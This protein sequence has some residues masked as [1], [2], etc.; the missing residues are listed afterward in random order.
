M[1]L[2]KATSRSW[3]RAA[4][5]TWTR[6]NQSERSLHSPQCDV[7]KAHSC[8]EISLD[9][10]YTTVDKYSIAEGFDLKVNY[11]HSVL[12]SCLLNS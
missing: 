11:V 3:K 5:G 4:T 7:V 6:S 1:L 12:Q 8:V 10:Q 9:E 2:S